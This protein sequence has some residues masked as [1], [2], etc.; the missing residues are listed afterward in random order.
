V[1]LGIGLACGLL[2]LVVGALVNLLI[3]RVPALSTRS[4]D[5]DETTEGDAAA[6]DV[7]AVADAESADAS[8]ADGVAVPAPA[9][10]DPPEA[11]PAEKWGAAAPTA[12]RQLV[13]VA[14]GL[15]FAATGIHF[16]A[17]WVLP[18]YLVFFTSLLA[19]SVIDMQ[20]H[21]IPNRIV[22][23]TIFLSIPLLVVAAAA[24]GE[25]S[26]LRAALLGACVAWAALFVIHLI[27]PGGMGFGDVRLAFV[28]G[29]FLGWLGL[30]KVLI[31]LFLG[32]L[33]GATIGVV[34]I[35]LKLRT[36]KDHIPFGP[37]L[38]AGATLAVF[39]GGP[40]SRF[41]LHGG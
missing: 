25:W 9:E 24:E 34:L 6:G 18:A 32:F 41:W 28:L 5:D 37:F 33:L 22:Y 27:S 4:F 7:D 17:T 10:G 31:G 16:G 26:H 40:I 30:A 3:D 14:T 21:I 36:R 23:P 1:N 29:L 15:V 38:A 11:A 8:E 12:S 19:I 13:H 20:H 2:G 39:F 35:A